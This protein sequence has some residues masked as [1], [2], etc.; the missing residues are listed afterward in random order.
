[1]GK[2]T[3]PK[4]AGT[5]SVTATSVASPSISATATVIVFEILV[6]ISPADAKLKPGGQQQFKAKVIGLA[7]Q[8]V[9]WSVTIGNGHID[10]SSGLFTAPHS[11]SQ[12]DSQVTATSKEDPSCEGIAS[13]NWSQDNPPP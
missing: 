3:A 7:D 12:G 2:Y 4:V 13:V 6:E 9:I 1:M 11:P 8:S 10:P 5:Y